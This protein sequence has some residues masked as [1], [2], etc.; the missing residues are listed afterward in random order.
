MEKPK[1]ENAKQKDKKIAKEAKVS[2]AT[3]GKDE[4]RSTQQKLTNC[5]NA[6]YHASAQNLLLKNPHLGNFEDIGEVCNMTC[7]GRINDTPGNTPVFSR[8]FNP[9]NILFFFN[10]ISFFEFLH[11]LGE[12]FAT[13]VYALDAGLFLRCSCL[14]QYNGPPLTSLPKEEVNL[15]DIS[16]EEALQKDVNTQQFFEIFN[17]CTHTNFFKDWDKFMRVPVR[18]QLEHFDIGFSP[19]PDFSAEKP[20]IT[21]IKTLTHEEFTDLNFVKAF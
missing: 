2:L 11:Q 10:G 6:R 21:N 5:K 13:L 9:T 1:M 16:L 20:D 7:F 17:E 3:G 14:L 19:V 12:L 18:V 4:K 8:E 15:K